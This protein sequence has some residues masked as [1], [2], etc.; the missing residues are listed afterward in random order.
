M[1]ASFAAAP[2][3]G[4]ETVGGALGPAGSQALI[5]LELRDFRCFEQMHL[6]PAAQGITVLAGPNGSGKTSLLEAVGYLASLRSFR[7]SQRDA[8]VRG[9]AD[10]AFLRGSIGRLGAAAAH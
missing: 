10:R 6:Q 4:H 2:G 3:V 5:D 8:L 7:T 9:A 1:R